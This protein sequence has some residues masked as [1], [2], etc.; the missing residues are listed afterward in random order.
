MAVS[1]IIALFLL[2]KPLGETFS[3]GY[4]FDQPKIAGEE[5]KLL[6]FNASTFNNHRLEAFMEDDTIFRGDFMGY[7]KRLPEKPDILCFQEFH[8]DDGERTRVTDEIVKI[9]DAPYYYSVPIW[10]EDQDGFFGIITFSRYPIVNKGLLYVGDSTTPNRGIFT[11]L[12]IGKD[13]VRVVNIHL[14]S[15]NIRLGDTSIHGPINK[16]ITIYEKL[17]LGDLKRRSQLQQVL[18]KIDHSPYPVILCGDFNS[19]PYGYTYQTVKKRLHNAFEEAGLGFGYTLNMFP[20]LVRLD[21]VFFSEPF[22]PTYAKV[23]RKF[24][25]SDHFALTAKLVMPSKDTLSK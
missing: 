25:S 12:R 14:H 6:T 21:N 23:V 1:C 10:Q 22:Q 3:L 15:M 13:T 24:P 7:L 18:D 17:H 4:F 8:H 5:I 11:D 9:T 16:A 19:F 2:Q 20:Y